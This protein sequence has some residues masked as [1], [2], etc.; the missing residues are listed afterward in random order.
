MKTTHTAYTSTNGLQSGEFLSSSAIPGSAVLQ[1]HQ[2]AV[3]TEKK[4]IDV[5]PS[6]LAMFMAYVVF[7]EEG[8]KR[9]WEPPIVNPCY[10]CL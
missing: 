8:A 1:H 6:H 9:D 7:L 4:C 10:S 2:N 3:F 5:K